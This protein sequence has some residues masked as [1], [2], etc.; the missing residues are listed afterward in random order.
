MALKG[1]G[2]YALESHPT[3]YD[4]ESLTALELCARA[5]AKVNECIRAF[6]EH[7]KTVV[8]GLEKLDKKIDSFEYGIEGYVGD[9]LDAHP[10]ATTT[11]L[12]GSLGT[13]HLTEEAKEILKTPYVNVKNHG[14]IGNG[15][16]DDTNAI[17]SIV[18]KFSSPLF[19]PN[20]KYKITDTLMLSNSIYCDERAEFIFAPS[21]N[22]SGKNAIHIKSSMVRLITSQPCLTQGKTLMIEGASLNVTSGDVLFLNGDIKASENARD[23]DT[24]RDV[25]K[26]ESVNGN[27][28]TFER[29]PVFNYDRVTL[30]KLNTSENPDLVL[31]GVKL[32][33]ASSYSNAGGN[34]IFVENCDHATIRNCNVKGF[35]NGNIVISYCINSRVVDCYAEVKHSDD[36]QYGILVWGGANNIV[37]GNVV[38]SKRTAIDCTRL[39]TD[40]VIDGNTVIGNISLHSSTNIAITNNTISDGCILIRGK[41]VVVSGNIVQNMESPTIDIEEMGIDGD[42]IIADNIFRGY[43]SVKAF[44]S[45]ITFKGNT[46][47]THKVREYDSAGNTISSVIRLMGNTYPDRGLTI[48][49]NSFRCEECEPY[50]AIECIA[51]CPKVANLLVCDNTIAGFKIGLHLAQGGS[52]AGENLI[53]KNNIIYCTEKGITFRAVNNT[54]IIGNTV[55]GTVKGVSGIER[56]YIDGGEATGLIIAQNYVKNFETAIKYVGGS[57]T[58]RVVFNDNVSVECD[59]LSYGISGNT[60]RVNNEM[61]VASPDGSVFQIKVDDNGTV[62]AVKQSWSRQ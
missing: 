49:G 29:A 62:N 12:K 30:D 11:V 48:Q 13:E 18:N 1:L 36:L 50:T 47:I 38:N 45:N 7:E 4:E 9:W 34:G 56:F 16:V 24:I 6:N 21:E 53:V 39:A 57:D 51:L 31:D 43:N 10:E 17:N 2:H 26:V 33:Y 32:R 8:E 19:F 44:M 46:F 14:V 15:I 55:I 61:F 42:H 41:G 35:D 20:G 25:L 59:A 40:I 52:E 23:Y 28:I 37:S 58:A 27:V 60:T 54:Q 22:V 3:V 5:T